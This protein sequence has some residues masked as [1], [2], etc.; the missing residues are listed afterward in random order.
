V[1]DELELLAGDAGVALLHFT[2]QALLSG[3]EDAFAV[4]VNGAAFEDDA[5]FGA[6]GE[7]D[8]RLPFEQMEQF[9]STPGRNTRTGS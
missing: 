9:I 1:E 6:V 4:G 5:V 7:R 3:E 8:G 2:E